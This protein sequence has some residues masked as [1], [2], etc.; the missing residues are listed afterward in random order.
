MAAVYRQPPLGTCRCSVLVGRALWTLSLNWDRDRRRARSLGCADADR[1][2]RD[3][4]KGGPGTESVTGFTQSHGVIQPSNPCG[5][6]LLN[7]ALC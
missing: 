7:G 2:G 6:T 4:H 5:P 1:S 3:S